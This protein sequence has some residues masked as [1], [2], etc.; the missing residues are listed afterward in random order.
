MVIHQ[1][2]FGIFAALLLLFLLFLSPITQ[3][4][5]ADGG[6]PNLAY[7][8]GTAQGISV[9]DIGQQKVTNTFAISGEPH[10]VYLSLDGRFLY[11]AQP[12]SG[13]VTLLAAKTGQ[14]VC[15]ANVPG[16]PTLL[17]FDAGINILYA[18]GNQANTITE[19]DPTNCSIKKTLTTSGNV[20][21]MSVAVVGSGVS[22]G[23]GNQL[24]VAT[25]KTVNVYT[26]SGQI[27]SIPI[28]G[29]PQYVT[30]PAG[31]FVY[32]TTR[33]GSVYA[34][35]LASRQPLPPL[36]TGGQFGPMDYDAI[37][38]EVYVP[39][40][41][42]KLIDVLSPITPGT[43]VPQHEPDHTIALGV[44]PQSIAI[45]SDG[46]LGFIALQGGNV[47]MLDIPGKQIFNTIHVGG[48]PQF[49][50]TGLYPPAIGNGSPQQAAQLTTVINIVAY[51]LVIALFIVPLLLLRRYSRSGKQKKAKEKQ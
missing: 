28:P 10:M 37:T 8:A 27:A 19:I 2:L 50:I 23:N 34:I 33:G 51:V 38:G 35:D 6:A 24:W 30:I 40:M 3:H 47:A 11:V 48:N 16:Q 18:A 42:H 36:L 20:Y 26:N 15:S 4:A 43:T 44:A 45:T 7:V 5:Y 41:Q 39:D 14:T 31:E 25:T 13:R 1:K 46:Q 49:I 17:A 12:E 29:G 21:G 32:V 22:G 9:I